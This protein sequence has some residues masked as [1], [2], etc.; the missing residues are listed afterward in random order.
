MVVGSSTDAAHGFHHWTLNLSEL[1]G[2]GMNQSFTPPVLLIVVLALL[3]HLAGVAKSNESGPAASQPSFILIISDD[4][5][6]GDFS[7]MGHPHIKTPN[8]DRL[9]RE[10]LTFTRGYVPSSLCCPSLASII[11]GLY[12]H[13]H[14]VTGNDPIAPKGMEPAEFWKSDMFQEGR[15]IMN[16]HL[17]TVPTLPR[18]LAQRNYVSLQTG[19]W[20]QGDYRRGGFTDGMT[21]GERH[22]DVGLIIGRE[23]MQPIYDFVARAERDKKPFF[24]W[25]APMMP[26]E[27]HNPPQRL[28]D[29]YA[30]VAPSLHVAKYWGMVEWFD[31]TVGTLIRHLDEQTLSENT[32]VIFVTD[33]GWITDPKSG[34]YA[35]KSKQSPYDGGLRTPIMV[36]WPGHVKPQRSNAL[37]SSLDIVPT[38]L[39]AAKIR[40]TS[41]MRGVNLL[42]PLAVAARTALFGE[43]FTHDSIEPDNPA[44]SLRWR[45]MVDRNW[46]LIIPDSH[47]Q[48]NDEVQLFDLAADPQEEHN[49]AA[50]RSDTVKTMRD[51][52]DAWWNGRTAD[53]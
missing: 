18:I 35:P 14:K 19:K 45:W 48:P 29:K 37:A 6:W 50:S 21:Q 1:S 3:V 44:A 11:T 28:L 20:W 40:P 53:R 25:Y 30:Q 22:G 47:N 36:R 5:A 33:N 43:C 7:F 49:L 17:E 31:E 24:V 42:D 15:E 10:S 27:P 12:P 34:S 38:I 46:K 26:H 23:T 9:A 13:Q 8:L 2:D 51:A 39:A 32:M 16:R 4:Q 41:Q 52:L